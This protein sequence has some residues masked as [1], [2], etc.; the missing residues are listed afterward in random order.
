MGHRQNELRNAAGLVLKIAHNFNHTRSEDQ[1]YTQILVHP[2]FWLVPPHFVCSGDGTAHNK[3]LQCLKIN[4]DVFEGELLMENSFA[5]VDV[6]YVQ[7]FQNLKYK[8]LPF[9]Q[10]EDGVSQP[11]LA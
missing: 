5:K 4:S 6:I 7:F 11:L 9:A 2:Y 8:S 1:F 10:D 3:L